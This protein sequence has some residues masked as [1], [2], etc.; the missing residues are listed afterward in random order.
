[1]RLC[2]S[3]ITG[4]AL[5]AAL[6]AGLAGADEVDEQLAAIAGVGPQGKGSK[7]ARQACERL[8]GQGSS[9]LPRLL[10]AMDTSNLVAANWY[11]TVYEKIVARELARRGGA[12]PAKQGMGI[13]S[14]AGPAGIHPFPL[15]KSLG[16]LPPDPQEVEIIRDQA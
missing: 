6:G 1:M 9:F 5:S 11:R 10:D 8:A 4:L 7:A 2:S 13:A 16:A 15:Q 12:M 14:S 3:L